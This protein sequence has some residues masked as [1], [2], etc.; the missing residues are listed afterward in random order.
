MLRTTVAFIKKS[1]PFLL[2]A[3]LTVFVIIAYN[4]LELLERHHR[5]LMENVHYVGAAVVLFVSFYL[6]ALL[7]RTV[8]T[9]TTDDDQ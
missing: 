1:W 6:I 7:V 5:K 4:M 2:A 3:L 9:S 8:W